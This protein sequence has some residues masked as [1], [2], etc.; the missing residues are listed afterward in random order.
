MSTDDVRPDPLDFDTPAA[1]LSQLRE[2][3]KRLGPT[4]PRATLQFM[5]RE[6]GRA[7]TGSLSAIFKGKRGISVEAAAGFADYFKLSASE[8]KSFE[9]L[10]E[11]DQWRRAR[12]AP[13]RKE[14]QIARVSLLLNARRTLKNRLRQID[15]FGSWLQIVLREFIRSPRFRPDPEW[16]STQLWRRNQVAEIATALEHLRAAD[17][18]AVDADGRWTQGPTPTL[19]TGHHPEL[20]AAFGR[21]LKDTWVE[22]AQTVVESIESVPRAD[23]RLNSRT[24]FLTAAEFDRLSALMNGFIEQMSHRE[25]PEDVDGQVYHMVMALVPATRSDAQP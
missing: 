19:A 8:R 4:R 9:L 12:I 16:L 17:V 24:M 10:V 7:S 23:R 6:L 15:Y 18:V 14:A 11:L 3:L 13:V 20:D 5:A 2:G 25:R 21:A 1:F 22:L